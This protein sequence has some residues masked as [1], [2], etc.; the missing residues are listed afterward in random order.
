MGGIAHQQGS[1]GTDPIW[2]LSYTQGKDYRTQPGM[3]LPN[4][5]VFIQHKDI[6]PTELYVPVQ[7]IGI[8]KR[9]SFPRIEDFIEKYMSHSP[10][11]ATCD[12]CLTSVELKNFYLHVK[13]CD[14]VKPIWTIKFKWD[15][16]DT[17]YVEGPHTMSVVR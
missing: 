16:G 10:N 6:T 3:T 15:N 9:S 7:S 14:R 4:I 12:G 5:Y 17:V 11:S 1:E 2:S 13:T 8:K